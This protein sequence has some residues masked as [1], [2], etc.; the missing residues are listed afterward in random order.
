MGMRPFSWLVRVSLIGFLLAPACT[1]NVPSG[2]R[3]TQNQASLCA[4][5]VTPEAMQL[6][7]PAVAQLPSYT[8]QNPQWPPPPIGLEGAQALAQA[9]LDVPTFCDEALPEGIASVL[10]QAQDALHAGNTG[11]ALDLIRTLL[12][13]S[14]LRYGAGLMRPLSQSHADWRARIGA[15][16]Q[17][18]EELALQGEQTAYD[19]LM[20]QV[21]EYFNQQAGE[22][23]KDAG[24][25]DA[26]RIAEEA[27]LLGQQSTFEKAKARLQE[28]AR[29]EL[30][31]AIKDFDPC[32]P[33]PDVLDQDIRDLLNALAKAQ[34]VGVPEALDTGS[35][36]Q[37]AS[38]LFEQA[39]NNM[40]SMARGEPP[41][42]GY[43]GT[44]NLTGAGGA[45]EISGSLRSCQGV[46]GPWQGQ[47]QLHYDDGDAFG[48]C[49]G[50]TEWTFSLAPDTGEAGGQITFPLAC[51]A[52]DDCYYPSASETLQFHAV[53][54]E[55]GLRM[56]IGSTGGGNFTMVCPESDGSNFTTSGPMAFFWGTEND[57]TVDIPLAPDATCP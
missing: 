44:F 40:E 8:R 43:Q 26:L 25:N 19:N 24:F 39:V 10:A 12:E 54:V 51:F 21:G 36:Y 45:A 28:T 3:V 14:T 35:L 29:Q 9:L 30:E 5:T 16:I 42:C 47:L 41:R 50:N 22:A 27:L 53:R 56:T 6:N 32:L 4:Q 37:Q 57:L 46:N 52:P 48:R 49:D 11:Q 13:S 38:T 1:L 7:L 31:Q 23:L 15:T 17:F 18:A 20:Q 33:N 34:L 2:Q 55:G